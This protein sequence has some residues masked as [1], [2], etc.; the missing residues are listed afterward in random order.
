MKSSPQL[1][2][3]G[4]PASSQ[5]RR[6]LLLAHWFSTDSE[7]S[8]ALVML[9]A[10]QSPDSLHPT[11]PLCEMIHWNKAWNKAP[12]PCP[13]ASPQGNTHRKVLG[14]GR[15]G[16]WSTRG[17]SIIRSCD[18]R[19]AIAK[20]TERRELGGDVLAHLC[21]PPSERRPLGGVMG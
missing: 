2:L 20:H 12:A 6:V 14:A 19:D 8:E 13:A 17:I 10:V 9:W 15:V 3:A 5:C 11:L 7:A 18:H 1:T 16:Q 21:F 4:S